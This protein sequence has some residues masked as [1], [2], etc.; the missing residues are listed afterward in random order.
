L[1]SLLRGDL[2]D[3]YLIVLDALDDPD[4]KVVMLALCDLQQILPR[5]T[6]AL[7]PLA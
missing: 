7:P 3:V 5:V 2:S 1:L 4:G 6:V